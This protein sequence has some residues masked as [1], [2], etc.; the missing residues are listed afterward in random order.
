MRVQAASLSGEGVVLARAIR[1]EE[2]ENY[3]ERQANISD[4]KRRRAR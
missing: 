4:R 1:R 3:N 2:K